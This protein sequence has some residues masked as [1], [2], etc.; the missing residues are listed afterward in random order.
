[1]TWIYIVLYFI[2]GFV[3]VLICQIQNQK[4]NGWFDVFGTEDGDISLSRILLTLVILFWPICAIFYM[5]GLFIPWLVVS[6]YKLFVGII[7]GTIALFKKETG[8]DGLE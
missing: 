6:V 3:F 2:I 8:K 5:V 1:M 4:G 7:F